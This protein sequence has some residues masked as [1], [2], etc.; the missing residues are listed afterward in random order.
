MLD[1]HWGLAMDLFKFVLV[2]SGQ[3]QVLYP[4]FQLQMDPEA[5]KKKKKKK[6]VCQ[7]KYYTLF[8]R[9]R[10]KPLQNR[11]ITGK[12]LRQVCVALQVQ[13]PE[14]PPK[15][16]SK[17]YT[18]YQFILSILL[19]MQT[20]FYFVWGRKIS[21]SFFSSLLASNSASAGEVQCVSSASSS[22]RNRRRSNLLWIHRLSIPENL[23]LTKIV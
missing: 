19:H 3:V 7:N 4:V 13:F 5:K 14:K 20:T 15:E 11:W 16:N 17:K 2:P 1:G 10:N 23:Q 12:R 6:R 18:W 8:K 21:T 22:L 9:K